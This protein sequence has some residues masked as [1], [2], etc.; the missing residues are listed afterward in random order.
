M[1]E[2]GRGRWGG[3]WTE[4]K[5]CLSHRHVD[6]V[7]KKILFTPPP[8]TPPLLTPPSAGPPPADLQRADQ[9]PPHPLRV[10]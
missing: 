5:S 2:R 4:L 6:P 3:E 8:V 7:I 9:G 1:N 10:S